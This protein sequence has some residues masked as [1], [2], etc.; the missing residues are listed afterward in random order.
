[1]IH[2]GNITSSL[3]S[4]LSRLEQILKQKIEEIETEDNIKH[5]MCE[6]PLPPPTS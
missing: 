2:D 3:E 4:K 6:T 5:I 1:M